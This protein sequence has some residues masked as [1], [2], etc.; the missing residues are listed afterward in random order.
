MKIFNKTT[1]IVSA[2]TLIIG[3]FFGWLI[4]SEPATQKQDEMGLSVIEETT[5]TCSMHPSIR[6][7]EPG[8]CPICGMDLIPLRQDDEQGSPLEVKM[9]AQ[10]IKLAN[11]QTATAEIQAAQKEVR[12]TGKVQTDETRIFSQTSHIGGRIES[13]KVNFTGEYVK[14]GQ[15]LASVYSPELVTAQKELF[16]AYKIKESQPGLYQAARD[17]LINWKLTNNQIDAILREGVV[18]EQI[19][20]RSDVSGVVMQRSVSVGDYIKKGDV[21]YEIADLSK[22][23]ILFEVYESDLPWVKVGSMVSYTVQSI[24]GSTFEGKISFIDPVINPATR[25]AKARISVSNKNLELKPEMFVV[26]RVT[27]VINESALTVPRSAVMWTGTRS[28]SPKVLVAW[29]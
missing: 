25:V 21:L 18:K 8:K 12:L 29:F 1:I 6:Q 10:A 22:L 26:G 14:N 3:L 15:I 23:W 7:Q 5:W 16:E 28:I 24:P 9:S 17:K 13:L 11:I 4:F 2:G 27:T 20:I 19:A